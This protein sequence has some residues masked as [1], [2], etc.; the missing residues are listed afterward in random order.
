M[1]IVLIKVLL[2]NYMTKLN[3]I[4]ILIELPNFNNKPNNISC[5]MSYQVK[6]LSMEVRMSI[7][8]LDCLYLIDCFFNLLLMREME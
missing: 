3:L 4:Q 8:L 7:I 2:A 6:L 5:F 1:K